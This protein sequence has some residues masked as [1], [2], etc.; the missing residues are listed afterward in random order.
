MS[1]RIHAEGFGP[2]GWAAYEFD[3][4]PN[5]V[6]VVRTVEK[7]DGYLIPGFVDVHIHGAFGIDFMSAPT[8]DIERWA[9]KMAEEGY[10]AFFPTTVTASLRDVESALERLPENHPMIPGFH[11]EGPFISHIFPGA[12]PPQF[13]LDAP[14]GAWNTVLS[15]PRLRLITLA[16]ENPGILPTISDLR[17]RG[18]VVSAGHTNA[19]Y[20]E[21]SS[22]VGRGLSHATHTY[23][24]MRGLHH[25]EAGTL[26]AVLNHD[27]ITAELIYDRLHVS[28]PAAEVLLRAK[29][30]DK[31][32]GISDCTQAKGM[33]PGTTCK[34]WDHEVVVGQGDV[35]LA[36]NG[37]LAGSAA[38]L[39]DVFRN[40]AEDFGPEV[41]TRLCSINPRSEFKLGEARRWVYLDQNLHIR[42][43]I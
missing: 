18:V 20:G 23:N 37:A 40:L 27:E 15:D 7:A 25:R 28:K 41:A 33:P 36:A 14:D 8:R 24:A 5:S 13:I 3:V 26:G 9:E 43:L 38:T 4:Q 32:I 16:P 29:P 10:A 11:L 34:M 39:L 35:R 12:Q 2:E 42:N 17:A 1:T 30:Q 6:E 19:T 22:A 21:I 31:V